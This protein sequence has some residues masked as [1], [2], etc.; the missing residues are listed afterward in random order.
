[1][2]SLVKIKNLNPK[3]FGSL[4][5]YPN[6]DDVEFQ[7][8]IKELNS[9]NVKAIELTGRKK[10]FNFQVLG[11]GCVSIVVVAL[12]RGNRRFAL[13]IRRTD[14]D[15]PDTSHEVEMLRIA[16]N[17]G[18][19]PKLHTY[20]KNFILMELVDG[21]N[22]PEWLETVRGRDRNKRVREV[23]YK[24][25]FSCRRL[26]LAGLDHGELSHAPKHIII[27]KN[28]EPTIIDF[29]AASTNR[30]TSNV[31][32]ICQYLFIGS[33][34]ADKIQKILGKLNKEKLVDR[35]RE[36]KKEASEKNFRELLSAVNIP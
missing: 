24:I 9:L 5:C 34:V 12:L 18:V 22:L 25:L 36:Y 13:K 31:R 3:D 10:A 11:K 26:D 16:N 14:A 20:T 30:K 2:S 33:G 4:I 27:D 35:I 17:V 29:E 6:F 1:L 15:R 23:L 7:L 19:G 8:R 32:S 28:D 21:Y